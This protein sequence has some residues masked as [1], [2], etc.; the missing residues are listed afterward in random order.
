MTGSPVSDDHVLSLEWFSPHVGQY[1]DLSPLD[2]PDAGCTFPAT[3]IECRAAEDGSGF[4]LTFVAGP[5]A[6]PEQGIYLVSGRNLTGDPVFLVP[7]GRR[8]DGLEYHAIFNN[9]LRNERAS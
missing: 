4:T 2:G 5:D 6:P 7:S 1:F 8:G 9:A 3:L